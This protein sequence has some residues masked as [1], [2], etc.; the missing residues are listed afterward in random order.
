[1]GTTKPK[2]LD[3][4][5]DLE[6][7]PIDQVFEKLRCN[8]E[9]LTCTDVEERL[10]IY[11][12]N[13]LEEKTESKFLK[14]LRYSWNPLSQ[15]MVVAAIMAIVLSNGGGKPPDW[16]EFLGIITLLLIV[17]V[18][19]ASDVAARVELPKSGSTC[20]QGEIIKVIV[21]ATGVHTIYRNVA[22]AYV[23]DSSSQVECFRNVSKGIGNFLIRF[24]AVVMMVEIIVMY[25]RNDNYDRYGL[26]GRAL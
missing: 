22:A 26:H 23:V 24:V 9:G 3:D 25:K 13:K 2:L 21:I 11:G 6:S 15:T 1:M 19:V 4:L 20:Q 14:S 18:K 5:I 17:A 7:I 16:Q 10:D 12:H 8:K